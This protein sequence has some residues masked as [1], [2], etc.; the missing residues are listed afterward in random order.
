MLLIDYGIVPYR[1]YTKISTSTL[2]VMPASHTRRYAVCCFHHAQPARFDLYSKH[3]S[4][5]LS[6]S[7]VGRE[8]CWRVHCHL[9][10][11][12]FTLSTF[13]LFPVS[14]FLLFYFLLFRWLCL[15]SHWEASSS[16]MLLP[17]LQIYIHPFICQSKDNECF[18]VFLKVRT[19][20]FVSVFL[21]NT[22]FTHNTLFTF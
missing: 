2:P 9:N 6:D 4:R 3:C 13:L 5:S 8:L 15:T 16:R 19:N 18:W 17:S 12:F 10:R 11:H 22:S 1:P 20:G 7:I 21:S 14:P